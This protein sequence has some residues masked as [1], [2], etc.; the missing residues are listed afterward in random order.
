MAFSLWPTPSPRILSFYSQHPLSLTY[1]SSS[2]NFS[3]L[4]TPFCQ[5]IDFHSSFG[6]RECVNLSPYSFRGRYSGRSGRGPVASDCH[7]PCWLFGNL[8]L[9]TSDIKDWNVHDWG[10]FFV[11]AEEKKDAESVR[12][13]ETLC[14]KYLRKCDQITTFKLV[15]VKNSCFKQEVGG[16]KS[17]SSHFF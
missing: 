4:S 7:W 5:N 1:C 12:M 9:P 10:L 2:L 14:S 15:P 11:V 3:L 8:W 17:T 16:V 6:H 13:V